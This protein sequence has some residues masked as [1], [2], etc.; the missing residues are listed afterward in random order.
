MAGDVRLDA[1]LDLASRLGAAKLATGHYAR[2]GAGGLLRVGADPAK[3]QSYM[4]AG[5]D[6]ASLAR[7]R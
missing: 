1:M 5:L 3:D 7:M 6:P 2:L 4:L